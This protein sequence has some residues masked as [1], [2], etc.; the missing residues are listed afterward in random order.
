MKIKAIIIDDEPLAIDVLK[1]FSETI[2]YISIEG[3]FT[4]P[5]DA[6]K[7]LTENAVDLVFCFAS[8]F[9]DAILCIRW[10]SNYHS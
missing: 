10:N 6:V 8:I 2:D 4:N 1:K 5:L 3:T 7:Y 9:N